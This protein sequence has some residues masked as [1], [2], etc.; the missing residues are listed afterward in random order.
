MSILGTIS[1]GILRADN[2]SRILRADNE[3]SIACRLPL[4]TSSVVLR[5]TGDAF[6]APFLFEVGGAE[7]ASKLL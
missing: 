1:S 2:S 7:G 5:L 6:L 3:V 4:G